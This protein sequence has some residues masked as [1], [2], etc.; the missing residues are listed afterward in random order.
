MCAFVSP[1]D[2]TVAQ[3]CDALL[4]SGEPYPHLNDTNTMRVVYAVFIGLSYLFLGSCR[5]GVFSIER[6][7]A[8]SARSSS[9][10]QPTSA[11]VYV[12][13]CCVAVVLLRL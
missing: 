9:H 3:R 4:E 10:S 6:S 8:G 11:G 12:C 7:G 13:C 2:P 1:V 5:P